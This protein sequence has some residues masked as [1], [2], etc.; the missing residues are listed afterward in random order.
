MGRGALPTLLVAAMALVTMA[1]A[2]APAAPA[3][4]SH[5]GHQAWANTGPTPTVAGSPNRLYVSASLQSETARSFVS[6]DF[7]R[8]DTAQLQRS[9]LV[10]TE[11]AGES[12]LANQ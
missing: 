12:T 10:L 5:L 9:T 6:F 2:T 7:A 11:A 1:V 4:E 8:V 3:A